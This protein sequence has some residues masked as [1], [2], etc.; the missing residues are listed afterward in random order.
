MSDVF[1]AS[2]IGGQASEPIREVQNYVAALN[3][4][5][6]LL[7]SLPPSLRL[8]RTIHRTLLTDVRGPI[9]CPV[10]F[11]RLQTGLDLQMTGRILRCLCH[12]P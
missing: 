7:E 12:H 10:S 3:E 5:L 8:V 11:E 4:G 1:D 9:G 2:A 6:E